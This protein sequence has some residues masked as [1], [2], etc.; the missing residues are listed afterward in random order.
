MFYPL[1]KIEYEGAIE[2]VAPSFFFQHATFMIEF[3]VIN[4][5][6]CLIKNYVAGE[7]ADQTEYYLSHG[8]EKHQAIAWIQ[9]R[10][11]EF[12]RAQMEELTGD[13]KDDGKEAKYV[14]KPQD[15]DAE[16]TT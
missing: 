7:K 10:Q 8:I 15:P 5:N 2:G 11:D 13:T 3:T 14:A 6:I 1:S 4:S 16:L 12:Y 9:T